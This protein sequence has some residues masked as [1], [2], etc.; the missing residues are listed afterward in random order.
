MPLIGNWK[1]YHWI[2]IYKVGARHVT[3][4]DPAI[5]LRK[6]PRDVFD[7]EFTG[8]CLTMVPTA[9]FFEQKNDPSPLR[10]ILH[11]FKPLRLNIFELFLAALAMQL[12]AVSMPLF[13]KFVIDEVVMQGE[14]RWLWAAVIGV[15]GAT[16]M[17]FFLAW[18]KT[19]LAFVVALKSNMSIA[20]AV[21]HRL[22]RLPM[23]YFSS[24]KVGD[25]TSRLEEQSTVTDFLTESA[26]EILIDITSAALFLAIMFWFNAYLAT[27]A[28]SF[29]VFHILIARIISPK[30]RLAFAEAFEKE[31]EQE[32]HL[33]ETLRGIETIKA[34]GAA[35]FV[36][37]RYDD[38]VATNANQGLKIEKISTTADVAVEAVGQ[39]A[40]ITILFIGAS[41]VFDGEMSIG[42]L[43]AFTMF[44]GALFEPLEG[45]IGAW[46]EYQETLNAIERLNDIL[47]REPEYAPRSEVPELIHI[48]SPRGAV[49]FSQLVFRYHP[50]DRANVLQN[51]SLD[52]APGE[53]VAFVGRS[54]CGKSTV[55]KLLYGML[56]PTDGDLRIDGFDMRDLYLPSLRRHIGSVPQRA[57]IFA[58]TVRDNIALGRPDASLAQVTEAMR[59][60]DAESF[61]TALP[62]GLES[63]LAEGGANL[64]GGQRQRLAIA[65]L[66]LQDPSIILLDEATSAL[67]TASEK[68]IMVNIA[69]RFAGRTVLIVAHRL[70]TVRNA[71]RIVVMNRGLVAE[72]GTHGELL[73]QNGLYTRL[74]SSA[75]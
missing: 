49:S 6:I 66:F 47:E 75:G 3:V 58:G 51:F 61:V 55:L 42:V 25:I 11:H 56:T 14:A 54:G 23:S 18:M 69:E 41:L 64:S 35:P 31:A 34:T 63:K 38:L 72:Q 21:Y 59:L 28:A 45:L 27:I 29:V 36:R 24:R 9:R 46:D 20:R 62:G 22:L 2:V 32:S 53:K 57:T 37:W 68:K 39:V 52:I 4:A 13:S 50:D 16:F 17:Q 5:G 15:G 33:L 40:S 8:Y 67:D 60:A 1:G 74:Q 44:A 7:K 65:R 26:T 70:S 43:V 48:P 71:D 12:V 30:L 10:G 19:E 73:A